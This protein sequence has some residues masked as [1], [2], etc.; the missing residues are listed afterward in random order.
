[1]ISKEEWLAHHNKVK[2]TGQSMRGYAKENGLS[3]ESF[4]YWS[5]KFKAAKIAKCPADGKGDFLPVIQREN[6]NSQIRIS[7]DCVDVI[8]EK[9]VDLDH[10]R[11]LIVFLKGI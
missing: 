9:N 11:S 5:R 8:V 4:R 1:M 7:V 10:L 6:E 2:S 3:Y